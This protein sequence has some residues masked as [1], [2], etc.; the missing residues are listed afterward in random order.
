MELAQKA[1]RVIVLSR[2]FDKKGRAK[3][4]TNCTLPLTARRCVDTLITERG[5]FRR[6]N[7]KMTLCSTAPGFDA[8]TAT[9]GIAVA[10][11]TADVTEPW[12]G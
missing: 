5:L 9:E 6:R 2:H 10:V 8:Q 7:G 12:G 3:L 11:E 1:R 4:V